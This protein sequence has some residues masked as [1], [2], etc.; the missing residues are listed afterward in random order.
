MNVAEITTLTPVHVGSGSKALKNIDFLYFEKLEQVTILD[1]VKVMQ[2][3]GAEKIS[4]WTDCIERG[5]ELL[6]LLKT[7]KEPLLPAD[8]SL[9]MI[10]AN[11]IGPNQKKDIKE[12]LHSGLGVPLIPGSSIKGSIR[13]ALFVYFIKKN[14]FSDVKNFNMLQ[15]NYKFRD[16]K[17]NKKYFGNSPDVD[18]LRFLNVMDAAFATTECYCSEVVNYKDN[19]W[20]KDDKYTQLIEAIPAKETASFMINYNE[21]AAKNWKDKEFNEFNDN[22]LRLES[23][24]KIIN[25]HTLYLIQSEQNFWAQEGQKLPNMVT[26]Y[27]NILGNLTE[28]IKNLGEYECVLRLGWGIGFLSMTGSWHGA[29]KNQDYIALA[30]DLR[31]PK[32]YNPRTVFPKTIR[33]LKDGIPLGFIKIKLKKV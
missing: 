6:N 9:R 26:N 14:E 17:L 2:I 21:I 1:T 28:T 7:I 5:D 10:R 11:L 3:L 32:K 8:I 4:L 18:I 22:L 31:Y 33:L 30:Q 16:T 12:Q 15:N 29:M 24:F 23:L 27:L 13:T 25:E 19:C 20:Q